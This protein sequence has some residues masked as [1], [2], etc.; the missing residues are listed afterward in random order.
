MR[1]FHVPCPKFVVMPAVG[2]KIEA[3]FGAKSLSH[4]ALMV[5]YYFF[6][7]PS[8]VLTSEGSCSGMGRSDVVTSWL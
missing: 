1:R 6:I 4:F 8:L 3:R 2:L 5:F 7:S